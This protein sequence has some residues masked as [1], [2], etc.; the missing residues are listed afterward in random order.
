MFNLKCR[1]RNKKKKIYTVHS[2]P[3][4]FNYPA[5]KKSIKTFFCSYLLPL[6]SNAHNHVFSACLVEQEL[7]VLS[8]FV[9]QAELFVKIQKK[10]K[11]LFHTIV[12]LF[13]STDDFNFNT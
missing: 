6:G 12:K 13:A 2:L 11:L 3:L 7:K 8:L 10:S 4:A 1:I 9:S 5:K